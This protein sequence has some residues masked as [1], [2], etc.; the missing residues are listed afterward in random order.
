[1]S[2]VAGRGRRTISQRAHTHRGMVMALV[3]LAA[4]LACSAGVSALVYVAFLPDAPSSRQ[5]LP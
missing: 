4:S 5:F 1:M 3:T 2:L